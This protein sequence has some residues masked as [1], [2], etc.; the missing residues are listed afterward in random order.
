MSRSPAHAA[1]TGNSQ[2]FQEA[3]EC[4]NPVNSDGDTPLNITCAHGHTSCVR[5]L[6][7]RYAN[8]ETCNRHSL[9]PLLSCMFGGHINI[10]HILVEFGADIHKSPGGRDPPVCFAA[11]N[12]L[13][14]ALHELLQLGADVEA[15]NAAGDRAVALA[16]TE[17]TRVL[18]EY[19][20][21]VRNVLD[22]VVLQG[23][24]DAARECLAAG[25]DI[26]TR[27]DAGNTPLELACEENN[28][29]MVA[30]LLKWGADIHSRDMMGNTPL[31]T[32]AQFDNHDVVAFL[33]KCGA[34]P[35]ATGHGGV[36]AQY[37]AEKGML[38]A[39][40]KTLD[41]IGVKH[42]RFGRVEEVHRAAC[43]GDVK[44]LRR[45][46]EGKPA[47]HINC[48]TSYGFTPLHYAMKRNHTKL[49]HEM[50]TMMGADP[51]IRNSRGA[52]VMHLS[53][54]ASN[55]KLAGFLLT[56][57][58]EL[59]EAANDDG[60]TPIMTAFAAGD[61]AL[62]ELVKLKADLQKVNHSGQTAL[63]IA[64]RNG[65]L[66]TIQKVVDLG[67]H[68]FAVRDNNGCTPLDLAVKVN[69]VPAMRLLA[70]L[71][72]KVTHR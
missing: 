68:A 65:F 53:L 54:T 14:R 60:N 24:V 22:R 4:D 62:E 12:V 5:V 71:E 57:A 33:V 21:D 46:M 41:K 20:A 43:S 18:I 25:A 1:E 17:T 15:T 34:D 38:I 56:K 19:G 31:I 66:E 48:Q 72:R 3:G 39:T 13:P 28:V 2:Y 11:H 64:V 27:D 61:K 45:A 58:P 49:V 40:L 9:T 47:S 30:L 51:C 52:T 55:L 69:N 8:T 7:Q 16:D 59:L 6:L 26:E 67:C 50:I 42:G 70:S 37:F 29:P 44:R 63:H 36:T 23:K 35:N 32:A 10:I